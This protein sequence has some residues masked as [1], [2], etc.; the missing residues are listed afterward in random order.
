MESISIDVRKRFQ[1]KVFFDGQEN[2]AHLP[3]LDEGD[4]KLETQ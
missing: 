1:A 4:E 2:A 3:L